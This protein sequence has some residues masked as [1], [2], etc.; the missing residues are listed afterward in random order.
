MQILLHLPQE[1]KH[2]IQQGAIAAG[3]SVNQFVVQAALSKALKLAEEI[4]RR[5]ENQP[6][7]QLASGCVLDAN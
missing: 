4:E 5:K 1:K 3:L 2:I 7:E 6:E